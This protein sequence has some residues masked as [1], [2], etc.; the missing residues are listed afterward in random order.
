MRKLILAAVLALAACTFPPP[1][2]SV[3]GTGPVELAFRLAADGLVVVTGRVNGLQDVDFILDTGA[4]VTVLIDNVTTRGLALDT[5]GARRLGDDPASPTGVIRSKQSIVFGRVTLSELTAVLIPGTSLPCPERMDALAFGGVV[6][7]DLFRRFVVEVD[8]TRQVVRLHEPA[9]WIAP[10]GFASVP[11]EFE[12]GHPYVL[13]RIRLADGRHV[14]TRLHLDT[15]MNMAL[16][17]PTGG[18]APFEAPAGGKTRSTCYVSARAP[19]IEGAAVSVELA[20]ARIADVVPLYTPRASGSAT[21][22]GGAIGGGALRRQPLVID[23]PG[24]R[25]LLG[26]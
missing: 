25:I 9:G 26:S 20:G 18:D 5:S 19:A 2:V 7:A 10:A 14:A 12:D 21:R 24:R 8:W 11:L 13:S 3:A 15:G 1:T 6:G 23:Y 17:L 22:H 4:P 16:S